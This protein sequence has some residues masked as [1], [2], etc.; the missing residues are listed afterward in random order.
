MYAH[1]KNILLR[2][3]LKQKSA[4]AVGLSSVVSSLDQLTNVIEIF[5]IDMMKDMLKEHSNKSN[6]HRNHHRFIGYLSDTAGFLPMAVI[7][8]A[9]TEKLDDLQVDFPNFSDVIDYI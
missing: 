8:Q 9:V 1:E 6:L 2:Q 3:Y 7:P 4:L 5:D